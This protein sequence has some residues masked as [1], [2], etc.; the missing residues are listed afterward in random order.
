MTLRVTLM[1]MTMNGKWN[2][3]LHLFLCSVLCLMQ[4]SC[5]LLLVHYVTVL[6]CS[7]NLLLLCTGQGYGQ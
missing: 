2:M 4:S 1:W 3:T 6:Y 7:N 5:D